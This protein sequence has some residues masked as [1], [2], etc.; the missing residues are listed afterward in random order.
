VLIDAAA[1]DR[2][3]IAVWDTGYGIL[4]IGATTFSVSSCN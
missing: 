2:L 4:T 1:G 3:R